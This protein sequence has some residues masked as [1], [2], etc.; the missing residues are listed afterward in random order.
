MELNEL[1]ALK[2]QVEQKK[3]ARLL[4]HGGTES[5]WDKY[6]DC[7]ERCKLFFLEAK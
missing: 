2:K 4:K 7:I 5:Q 3:L 1:I 6:P